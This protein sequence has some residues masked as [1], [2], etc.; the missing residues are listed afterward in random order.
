M[1]WIVLAVAMFFILPYLIAFLIFA[2]GAVVALLVAVY[3]F[4]IGV[5]GL[6]IVI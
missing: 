5:L 6:D 2:F 1:A 3:G 4:I